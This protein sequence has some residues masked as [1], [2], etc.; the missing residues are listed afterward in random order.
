M[1]KTRQAELNGQPVIE[2]QVRDRPPWSRGS[3]SPQPAE[4]VLLRPQSPFHRLVLTVPEWNAFLA[5]AKE[6]LYDIEEAPADTAT[7]QTP[8]PADTLKDAHPGTQNSAAPPDPAAAGRS[9]RGRPRD[10]QVVA[11]PESPAP[12]TQADP[13][14]PMGV[15]QDALFPLDDR[16]D[17]PGTRSPRPAARPGRQTPRSG[18]SSPAGQG[19]PRRSR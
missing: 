13:D 5:G 3:L 15:Q 19:R 1:S 16:P 12:G 11:S 9:P 17:F 14:R 7:P 8:G 4:V 6:G 10:G 2:I 18:I